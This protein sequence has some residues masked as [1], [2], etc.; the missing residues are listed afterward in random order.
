MTTVQRGFDHEW[1]CPPGERV[2]VLADVTSPF[3]HQVVCD[4]V[5]SRAPTP[6]DVRV[7]ATPPSGSYTAGLGDLEDALRDEAEQWTVPVRVVWQPASRRPPLPLR[8]PQLF[9]KSFPPRPGPLRERVMA[10]VT[11]DRLQLLVAEPAPTSDLRRRWQKLREEGGATVGHDEHASYARFVA[12]QSA[13]ALGRA[14]V[15]ALGPR[16]K[17]VRLVR[18]EVVARGSWRRGIAK[19][20]TELGR[21]EHDVAA[22]AERYL[23]EMAASPNPVVIDVF[24]D[25]WHKA[26]RLGYD[27]LVLVDPSQMERI[28]DL[29]ARTQIAVLWTHRTYIDAAVTRWLFHLHHLPPLHVIGGINMNFWPLG[30]LAKRSGAVMHR[31][32]F[33]DNPVYRFTIR[34]YVGYLVEKRFGLEWAPEGGRSRTGRL[35]PLRP[36]LLAY[37]ADAVLDG[38]V[39]DVLLVPL[40]ISYDQLYDVR[41]FADYARGGRKSAESAQWMV[42]YFR[43]QRAG[44]GR[45]Y[46][47]FGEPVSLAQH[48]RPGVDGRS[49]DLSGVLR[50]VAR[51]LERAVVVTPISVVSMALLDLDGRGATAVEVHERVQPLVEYLGQRR[52]PVTPGFDADRVEGVRRAL[53][54]LARHSIDRVGEGDDAVFA[55]RRGREVEVA[56]YANMIA[57]HFLVAALSAVANTIA[58]RRGAVASPD[59]ALGEARALWQLLSREYAVPP[60]DGALR[61][62]LADPGSVPPGVHRRVLRPALETYAVV[63]DELRER[64]FVGDEGE[65][66]SRSVDRLARDALR[67]IVRCPDAVSAAV[68]QN[69]VSL[70]RDRGLLDVDDGDPAVVAE[71]QR[72]FADELWFLLGSLDAVGYWRGTT[73]S[74]HATTSAWTASRFV[75]FSTSWRASG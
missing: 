67:G 37:V 30:P 28:W 27:E 63:A 61:E 59:A 29:M 65:L 31:R 38:R 16:F 62:A 24:N 36:G 64:G 55:V 40:S 25:L 34:E 75:S 5:A 51:E 13:L 72:A 49:H 54:D 44:F 48:L 46:A 21:P 18:E 39:D 23:D 4:W 68:V 66:V 6:T 2:V 12:R 43:G 17:V 15:R 3:E 8:L 11:P 56:Y 58:S 10:R 74:S 71:R 9:S 50:E 1:P 53:N 41:E 69:A 35:L 52:V 47:N 19:L 60:E 22:D 26:L 32:S 45:A 14:E 20:A 73:R 33:R 57:H 7:L 70:A 42:R